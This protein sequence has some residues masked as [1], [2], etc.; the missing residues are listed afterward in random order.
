[1]TTAALAGIVPG[2]TAA[3]GLA[4]MRRVIAKMTMRT[5]WFNSTS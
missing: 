5:V 1:M 4:G 2:D 3:A